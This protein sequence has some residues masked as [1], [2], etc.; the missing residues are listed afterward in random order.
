MSVEAR[1]LKPVF[2]VDGGLSKEFAAI[3]GTERMRKKAVLSVAVALVAAG[4]DA[5]TAPWIPNRETAVPFRRLAA[6]TRWLIVTRLVRMCRTR[7]MRWQ[8][9]PSEEGPAA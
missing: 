9:W 8:A 2:G 6:G 1:E 7:R 5:F 3:S 4:T